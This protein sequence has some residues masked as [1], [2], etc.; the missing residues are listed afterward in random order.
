[1]LSLDSTSG[2]ITATAVTARN[3]GVDTTSGKVTLELLNCPMELDVE[4]TSGDVKLT[5]PADSGFRL[6]FDH[7]SGDFENSDFPLSRRGGS[8]IA[9]DG[10]AEFSVDTTSGDL[11]IYSH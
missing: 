4:T 9:G 11:H 10:S 1:M 8:Y 2:D 6:E 7:A 5:L 3:V